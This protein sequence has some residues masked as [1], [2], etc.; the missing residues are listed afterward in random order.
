[1]YFDESKTYHDGFVV[2]EV[3]MDKYKRPIKAKIK[4]PTKINSR[5][6]CI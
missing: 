2:D 6:D 4:S 5:G 1:M 3:Y